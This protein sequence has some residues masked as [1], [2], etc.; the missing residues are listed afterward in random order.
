MGT[1]Y[2]QRKLAKKKWKK[3]ASEPSDGKKQRAK[4]NKTRRLCQ[5]MCYGEP[6]LK[7]EDKAWDN[8][9]ISDGY[10]SEIEQLKEINQD[11]T[12]KPK[13]TEAYAKSGQ[14][15]LQKRP[16]MSTKVDLPAAINTEGAAGRASKKQKI[17]DF[18]DAPSTMSMYPVEIQ[19]YMQ[20]EGFSEPTEIQE[21]CWP[22]CLEG[23]DVRAVAEPGSGKTLG[24]LLPSLPW[25]VK[26]AHA[27]DQSAS[28]PGVLILLP[29][30]ELAQQVA[31]SCRNLKG[32]FNLQTACIFGGGDRSA[33]E[34][35]I[36]KKPDIVVATP[37]RLLDFTDASTLDLSSVG[38]LVLDEADKML[39]LGLRPQL[40]R[41]REFVLPEQSDNKSKAKT[42]RPQVLLFTATMPAEVE[43]TAQQWQSNP[44]VLQVSTSGAS[45]SRTVVQVVQVCAEHKKPKKLMKH[46]GQIKEAGKGARNPPRV[47]VFANRIKTVRFLHTT[48]SAAGFKAAMLHGDRTQAEREEAMLDFRSGKA[49]VLVATDVAARGLHIRGLPYII[50][51]D[52]PSRLE[53]YIHRVGRT[54]RLATT[55]HAFSFFTRNLAP[56]ARPLLALLQ[57]HG[58]AVD[59]N[60]LRLADAYDTAMGKLGDAAGDAW[61]PDAAA[62]AAEDSDAQQE[63]EHHARRRSGGEQPSPRDSSSDEED[64]AKMETSK[65]AA[66]SRH[67]TAVKTASKHKGTVPALALPGLYKSKKASFDPDLEGFSD[68]DAEKQEHLAA[69]VPIQG[70]AGHGRSRNAEKKRTRREGEVA[71]GGQEDGKQPSVKKRRALPGRLRKKLA[72]QRES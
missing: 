13:V 61:A 55:G 71:S 28:G 25:L 16:R 60:L 22:E 56:L 9:D 64:E 15:L 10:D 48:I 27:S 38:Y 21:R 1:D 65:K 47:L 52:F 43:E 53:P 44:V 40:D 19:R 23:R 62:T 49:Q 45:I 3:F 5:G 69:A 8:E 30:R 51:Y 63:H 50:N 41:I 59:P 18:S 14:D 7:P 31:A 6:E 66:S 29:T 33:Q 46:L 67:G 37:G 34:A 17:S 42:Q 4:R 32:L 36:K 70:Y 39:S 20:A 12:V 68:S 58:Q 35:S 26:R 54:G 57:E 2:A 11:N 24:Y 72:K